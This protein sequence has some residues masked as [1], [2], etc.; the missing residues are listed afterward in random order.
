MQVFLWSILS[1]ALP[2]GDNRSK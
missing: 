1:D 2:T